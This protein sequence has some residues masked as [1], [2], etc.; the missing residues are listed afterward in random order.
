[1]KSR[2]NTRE[3]VWLRAIR[4]YQKTVFII[5]AKRKLDILRRR[6]LRMNRIWRLGIATASLM[7]WL[8]VP[9]IAQFPAEIELSGLDGTN[10]FTLANSTASDNFGYSVSGAGDVNGDGLDDFIAS[11]P[12][13]DPNGVVNSGTSYVLFGTPN[14]FGSN[15]FLL[16]NLNGS[17]GFAINGVDRDDYSGIDVSSAGDFNGDG[18]DDLLVIASRRNRSGRAYIVFGK[19]GGFGADFNLSSIDGTNGFTVTDIPAPFRNG[20][21][22]SDLGDVNGDGYDDIIVGSEFVTV[23]IN[24]NT[25]RAYVVFGTATSA[26]SSSISVNSLDG[27]NGFS[28]TGRDRSTQTGSDVSSAGDIN[29]DGYNDILIGASTATPNNKGQAG[30]AYI[31]FG[32]STPF[33]A[34]INLASLQSSDGF[35]IQG[36]V[37]GERTGTSVS[38]AGDVNADGYDDI[39]LGAP[40][41]GSTTGRA[42]LIFGKSTP[43]GSTFDLASINGTDATI[44]IGEGGYAGTSVSLAGDINSD[45]FDD[46]IIGADRFNRPNPGYAADIG[47]SYVMF[48][49]NAA[50]SL[51]FQL[52]SLNGTNGFKVNGANA[53]D[54]SGQ[55]VSNLGDF[56][57]DGGDDL[58][59]GAKFATG[60]RGRAYIIYGDAPE[61][62]LSISVLPAS[63]Q[64]DNA[65]TITY[66]ITSS[67]TLTSALDVQCS[68]SGTSQFNQDYFYVSGATGYFT[69]TG[70]QTTIPAGQN[71]VDV[72]LQV[73]PDAVQEPDETIILTLVP[74]NL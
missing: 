57:G 32:K 17:D 50:F 46:V 33:N 15:E 2:A 66:R 19:S 73:S 65:S 51:S 58:S 40:R 53:S 31:I 64:E 7:A 61:P 22:A 69:S 25:G 5:G 52:S 37:A 28:V 42:Y 55:S 6:I 45:G 29:G 9:A 24:G 21:R 62:E 47:R 18:F 27:T 59:I 11:V 12:F 54:F 67:V 30:E 1:M 44:L 43:F 48:G 60:S 34:G 72:V 23:G 26:S 71:Y 41:S 16:P 56:N 68:V 10:G 35:T 36:R 14:N 70:L 13:R 20:F 8:N 38:S 74:F 49:T 39:I 4:K 63:V 3:Q